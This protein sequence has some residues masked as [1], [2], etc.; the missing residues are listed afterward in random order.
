MNSLDKIMKELLRHLLLSLSFAISWCQTL[1]AEAGNNARYELQVANDGHMILRVGGDQYRITSSFSFP[2][3]TI[4]YHRLGRD[5]TESAT[6]APQVTTRADGVQIVTARGSHYSLQRKIATAGHR[7]E[8]SDTLTSIADE[9]VGV[10]IA[11]RIETSSKPQEIR[12]GGAVATSGIAAENPTIF[13]RLAA[14]SLGLFA[15]DNV[16]RVQFHA[17]ADDEAASYGLRHLAL[18]PGESVTL[19]WTLYP[20]EANSDY[21][22]FINQ[23][24]EDLG[25]NQTIVGPGGWFDVTREPFWSAAKNPEALAALLKRNRLKIVL[26]APWLDYENI[27][28]QSKK[29]IWRDE[30]KGL[31]REAIQ[32]L[33]NIDPEIRVL[34]SLEAPFVGLPQ[35]LIDDLYAVVPEPKKQGY[36]DMT[37]D[38]VSVFQRHPQAWTQWRD[39]LVTNREGLSKFELYYREGL[40]FV[41]LT[42]RPV[43]GNGQHDYLMEQARFVIEDVGF[44]G[45]YIDSFT[46]A[47]HSYYGYSY[48]KWDGRT[49]DIASET[50]QIVARYTDLALSGTG[51]RREVIEYGIGKGKMVL[52][53]GHPITRDTQS[54]GHLAFNESEWVFEP[55]DWIDGKPSW[56]QRPCEAHLST[57]LALGF[58]PSRYGAEGEEN[59]ARILVKGAIAFLRHGILYFHYSQNI[60]E[61]GPGSGQFGPFNHMFPIT[62]VRLGEGFV[63]GRERIVT[64][65]SREFH[66][67]LERRPVILRF[68]EIGRQVEH[69]IE[70][71]RSGAGWQ[72]PVKLNDW[73]NIVVL[74]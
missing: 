57:P 8:I 17:I 21:F 49:V 2:D 23:L 10:L 63:E 47:Q 35:A 19:D 58:R 62:P 27:N 48:D 14:S 9:D 41:A 24:R 70:P 12:I 53:N 18:R 40:P 16:S 55:L 33:H 59:Y 30:Y 71:V 66:W 69:E 52:V 5:R 43:V 54:L 72:V 11:N 45:Y 65:V 74:E 15:R 68:D 3:V 51:S 4:G 13:L 60:P 61:S 39:S 67:P 7:V 73:N 44:D 34:A 28:R 42:V 50:G 38:M 56:E 46:G 6:W 22:G 20:F 36:Y 26:T 37:A 64:V 25:V 31:M 1:N 32:T 29:L